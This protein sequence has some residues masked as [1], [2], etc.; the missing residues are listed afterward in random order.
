MGMGEKRVEHELL[1]A[2]SILEQK[3]LGKFTRTNSGKF[4]VLGWNEHDASKA[5]V[6]VTGE[7]GWGDYTGIVKR[8]SDGAGI[9]VAIEA[10]DY[11]GV[12]S[13]AQENHK[14]T[15]EALGGIHVSAKPGL[16]ELYKKLWPVVGLPAPRTVEGIVEEARARV[17][18][19][20]PPF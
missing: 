5:R 9:F 19:W 20:E 1:G 15:V 6:M 13:G 18:G 4:R 12:A 11:T 7:P 16:H 10:K 8:A 14:K 3:G 2:L 17:V